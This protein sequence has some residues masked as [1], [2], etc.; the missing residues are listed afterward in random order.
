MF[1]G[2]WMGRGALY[3]PEH[4]AVVDT[5]KG[6][7]GRFTYRAL[8]ARAEAL[9]GWLRDVAGVKRGDRVGLVAHN[10]VEYLD[11]LFACGKI[12]AIFVP[13]NW[14]L[15]AAELT[16]L[17]RDIRPRVL[18]FG[19]DF[20][21]GVA[22]VRERIGDSLRLVALEPQGLPG[23]DAYATALSHVPAAPVKNDA[24]AE[25]DILCLLFT[26]GTTGRSKGARISYRMV[27]WNTLN[28]LVHEVLPGDVTVTHTPMF[29]TGGLLVYTVPLLTVGGTVVI[30]RRWDPEA[31]LDLIPR[32]K[33][34]LFFAVPTQYQQLQESPRFKSTSFSSVRFM[35]SGGAALP[36][37]LI[38]AW[39]AV[40]PVP[41]K[42]GFGMTEF[43]PGLFSMG[44]EFAVSKAGSIGRPNYFI[45]AKLVDDDGREV[46][47]GEVGELLLKGPSMCS[48]YFEDEAAT[49]E[50]IDAD[51]WLHTGDLARK[52]EDGFFFIAG[53]KKDMFI[54]GGENVYPLELEGALYEHPAVHQCAV[55]GVPDAKWGEV[56]RAFV[57]LKPGEQ[58]SSEALL[59]H[60]R[61][62]VARFKVPK[63]VDVVERLPISAAGKILKREL[64]DAA[65]AADREGR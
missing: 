14:R 7:A 57:V 52:D 6:D 1:I 29:H 25:E 53:R 37:P 33:V 60:L 22:Q 45:A 62:R 43:G 30:M 54:S 44:P 17:V 34:T 65:I 59:E 9:G 40:H 39:Q 38:Q 26:G 20:R 46:P 42:Q 61:G 27:A 28:T 58:A 41:F 51:G 64:R 10:G 8:N 47:V 19:D 5:A 32:E 48:G 11:A 24:V 23:A 13:Y 2:D 18:L 35:T 55:V 12:G 49:R 21:D 50:A 4:V 31:L 63:R 56:G 15:H 16:D 36:V 3:W